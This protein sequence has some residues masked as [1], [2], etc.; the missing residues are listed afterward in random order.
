M[1]MMMMMRNTSLMK[2]NVK[3]HD[4]KKMPMIFVSKECAG[5][6]PV[7][8]VMLTPLGRGRKEGRGQIS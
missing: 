2:E 6:A 3:V 5:A 4:E 8:V 1:L 7:H